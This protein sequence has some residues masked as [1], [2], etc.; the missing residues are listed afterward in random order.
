MR[1]VEFKCEVKINFE[2][3]E[4]PELINKI[5]P[6][7]L[8]KYSKSCLLKETIYIFSSLTFLFVF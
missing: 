4:M 8:G 7:M 1:T 2:L 3:E 5:T 6:I